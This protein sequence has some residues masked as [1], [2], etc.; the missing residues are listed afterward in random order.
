MSDECHTCWIFIDAICINQED[1]VERCHQ[2]KLMGLIYRDAE[3]VIAWLNTGLDQMWTEESQDNLDGVYDALQTFCDS[4]E[5]LSAALDAEKQMSASTPNGLLM[6]M[7][8]SFLRTEYKSRV[9]IV[10]EVLLARVFTLRA[11][12]LRIR[13]EEFKALTTCILCYYDIPETA[14][15]LTDPIASLSSSK[16]WDGRTSRG[17]NTSKHASTSP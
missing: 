17:R 12:R 7:V 16:A 8:V 3:E 15:D 10:Q 11:R 1:T 5:A 6:V 2:V 4:K 14:H 9:W 13:S